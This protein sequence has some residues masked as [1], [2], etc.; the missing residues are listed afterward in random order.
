MGTGKKVSIGCGG[1][2]LLVVVALMLG[3][4]HVNSNYAP[5]KDPLVIYERTATMLDVT[6]PERFTPD[7]SSFT[8]KPLRDPF[9]LFKDSESRTM[10]STLAIYSRTGTYS[11]EQMFEDFD[12]S[13]SG[14]SGMKISLGDEVSGEAER[15]PV[16]FNG[17]EYEVVLQEG[18]EEGGSMKRSLITILPVQGRTIMILFL[19]PAESMPSSAMQELL[20]EA[21][22]APAPPPVP[23]EED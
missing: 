16:L 10:E 13:D 21:K 9:V 11:F 15:F 18:L 3:L 2:L 7:F 8:V 17:E 20:Q 23:A 4:R 19:G 14:S 5:T 22:L 6:I 1:L 12:S